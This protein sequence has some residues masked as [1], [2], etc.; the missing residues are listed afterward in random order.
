MPWGSVHCYSCSATRL[1]TGELGI[2]A[3]MKEAE[4]IAREI[5][6]PLTFVC[7]CGEPVCPRKQE[8][9]G[10]AARSYA[11]G[12]KSAFEEAARMCNENFGTKFAGN[13]APM[14]YAKAREVSG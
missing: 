5:C 12:R 6:G 3:N 7:N 9:V 8:V 4:R 2:G 11:A 14:F 13:M 10:M 1:L